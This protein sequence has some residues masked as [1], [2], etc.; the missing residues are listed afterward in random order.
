MVDTAA[1]TVTCPGQVNMSSGAIEYLA[2]APDGK[3]HE[4]L[5]RLDIR[6]LHLQLA[7]LMLNLEP[8]NTLKFQ[9]DPATP[10]GAPVSI[11]VRWL[12]TTGIQHDVPA[13][14]LIEQAPKR[15]T[16]PPHTW[17]FTGSRI[18]KEIGFEADT[19]KSII[20]VWHDPSAIIDN[21]LPGGATNAYLV[22]KQCP[23]K[24]TAVELVIAASAAET[25]RDNAVQRNGAP[26]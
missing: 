24:L 19:E 26:H 20:A 5:L 4:S 22:G 15:V 1:R 16:M 12:D 8:K 9:G 6:P 18:L 21:P 11:R 2:V 3:L 10:Q 13:E 25:G 17:V 23:A 14:E 7:L